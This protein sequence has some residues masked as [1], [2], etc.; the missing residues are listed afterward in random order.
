MTTIVGIEYDD[1]C[2]IAA[3]SLTVGGNGR[4]YIHSSVPKIAERGSFLVAGSGDAQPCDAL[5]HTWVP[6]RVMA[7]DK[8]DLFKFMVSKV[9]PSMRKCIKDSGYEIDK[10]D[11]DAGFDFLIAVGGELFEVDSNYSVA[12]TETNIYGVGS[13]SPFAMGALLVGANIE[14]A[15]Q[16]SAKLSVNTEGPFLVQKQ[17]K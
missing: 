5:Q 3:D 6:P 14:D 15:I 9:V 1:Y 10:D 11:K 4:R 17:F 13:G 7:K 12:K 2:V 8:E 16:A